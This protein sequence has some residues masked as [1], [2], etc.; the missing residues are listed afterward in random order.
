MPN[1]Q[2]EF[3]PGDRVRYIHAPDWGVGSIIRLNVIGEEKRYRVFFEK[4]RRVEVLP[5]DAIQPVDEVMCQ[6]IEERQGLE[7]LLRIHE[8]NLAALEEEAARHSLLLPFNLAAR[9]K[10]E[11]EETQTILEKLL[12]VHTALLEKLQKEAKA[13]GAVRLPTKLSIQV[14]AEKA[15]IARLEEKLQDLLAGRYRQRLKLGL[16]WLALALVIGTAAILALGHYWIQRGPL[17]AGAIG[18]ALAGFGSGPEMRP[19]GLGEEFASLFYSEL[20]R[21][22]RETGLQTQIVLMKVGLIQNEEEARRAAKEKKAQLILWGQIPP[23]HK[24]MLIPYFSLDWGDTGE[25]AAFGFETVSPGPQPT[26]RVKILASFTVGLAHL[27]KGE[28]S[29]AAEHFTEALSQA[30]RERPGSE[31]AQS[32]GQLQAVM[33]LFRGLACVAQN[34]LEGAEADYKEA[35]RHDPAYLR[36]HLELGNIYFLQQNFAESIAEYR[37][38]AESQT[39]SRERAFAY[40]TMGLAHRALGEVE[41]ATYALEMAISLAGPDETL[42]QMAE[43]ALS[44]IAPMPSPTYTASLTPTMTDT[45][46]AT[47]TFTPTAMRSPSRPPA[48]P[49]YPTYT[50]TPR[51]GPL[52]TSTPAATPAFTP[53][54]SPTA[55]PPAETPAPPSSPAATPAFTPAVPPTALPPAETPA[56]PSSPAATPAFTPA[57]SPTALPT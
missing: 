29:Q 36:P 49:L 42:R 30:A 20:S 44:T 41:K 55:L 31:N 26:T 54:P 52:P 38:V 4:A 56:P 39:S 32:L 19:T 13:C 9:L 2:E 51:P 7:K 35:S 23:G 57:P 33:Y 27:L 8:E 22:L 47:S 6:L 53:A 15:D 10:A 18:V 11:R 28:P 21:K 3:K 46:T 25:K 5:A 45:P 48:P 17:P 1:G 50:F 43:K 12:E 24:G 37:Q 34:D 14:A 16:L 40:Y